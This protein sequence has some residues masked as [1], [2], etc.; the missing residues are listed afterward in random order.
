MELA[1][2]A[3]SVS[4]TF[5]SKK[6]ATKALSSVSLAVKKGEVFG[7]LGPNGAGKTT[8][9]NCLL[10]ITTLDS[11][12]VRV[13]GFDPDKNG[14]QLREKTNIVSG[15]SGVLRGLTLE[16]MLYY[17]AMLYDVP[18]RG[19]RVDEVIK[20]L[21]LEEKRDS[22]VY[23]FSSGFRQ[24]FFLAKALLN[25][26]K[27]LFLDE[28]TVG[29][30]VDVAIKVRSLI[31]KLK[32]QGYT[33]LL[34]THYMLEADELC[35]RIALINKGRIRA[36]GTPAQLKGLIR[37]ENVIEVAL[38][39]PSGAK[40]AR[41][42]FKKIS[43]VKS[44]SPTGNILRL[45]VKDYSQIKG[46]MKTVLAQKLKIDSISIVEPTL[47]EVFLKLTNDP[48]FGQKTVGETNA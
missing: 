14:V 31:K 18:N 11:G 22:M 17:Y 38:S 23:L 7:L 28:P 36:Q 27:V 39:K 46:V 21:S 48:S 42:H 1:I 41:A 26:P 30:D 44:V 20:L 12:S 2:D 37:G 35:D 40:T 32:K 3:Q 43:G 19:R 10:G 8:L 4:K 5:H 9:I 29:L 15:F 47:E 16:Q 33:I 13:L 34:T 6:R 45:L 25:K 24:R